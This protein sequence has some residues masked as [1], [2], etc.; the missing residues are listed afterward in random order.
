MEKHRNLSKSITKGSHLVNNHHHGFSGDTTKIFSRKKS[1]GSTFYKI[2]RRYTARSNS[3]FKIN[4][5]SLPKQMAKTFI[6]K[7]SNGYVSYSNMFKSTSYAAI[8]SNTQNKK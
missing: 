6:K 2:I 1:F 8:M 4:A 3:W 5:N 7:Q